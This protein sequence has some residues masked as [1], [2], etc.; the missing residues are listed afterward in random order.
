MTKPSDKSEE[1]LLSDLEQNLQ[2]NL[3]SSSSPEENFIAPN[4]SQ[5]EFKKLWNEKK[6][7]TTTQGSIDDKTNPECTEKISINELRVDQNLLLKALEQSVIE[8][9]S[10]KENQISEIDRRGTVKN[11][12]E[13]IARVIRIPLSKQMEDQLIKIRRLLNELHQIK[14]PREVI[15]DYQVLLALLHWA[16]KQ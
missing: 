10:N 12:K 9:N 3:Y 7:H 15:D 16:S 4:L 11:S 5:E 14:K 6:I 2:D 8:I 1:D 13:T